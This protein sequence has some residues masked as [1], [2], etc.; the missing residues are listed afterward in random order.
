MTPMR[1]SGAVIAPEDCLSMVDVSCSD[2]RIVTTL[3]VPVPVRLFL[4]CSVDQDYCQPETVYKR[5]TGSACTRELHR[6]LLPGR[7]P[8]LTVIPSCLCGKIV[9]HRLSSGLIPVRSMSHTLRSC[10]FTLFPL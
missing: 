3:P 5:L 6:K 7:M 1:L 10:K 8:V 4:L 9:Q 2:E